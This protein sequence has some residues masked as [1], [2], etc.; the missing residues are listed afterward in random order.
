MDGANLL[1]VFLAGLGS[2]IFGT[3]V[4]GS[5]LITT[6]VLMLL[7]VPPHSAI[8]TDRMG[9]TGI[10]IAGLYTFHRKGLVRYGIGFIV[11]IPCLLGSFVGANIALQID[12]AVLRKV[13]V[14]LTVILL[15]VVSA[16]PKLGVEKDQRPLKTGDYVK[17]IFFSLLVG[18]YSGFYGAG[19]AIFLSY[20]MVLVFRQTF[21]ESAATMKVG[22][23][24]M[25]ATPALTFAYHGAIHYPFALVMFLGSCVGSFTG[26]HYSE[27]IG[28]VWIQ[29]LFIGIVL[30][31]AVKLLF[32]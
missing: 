16:S 22:A 28:N 25:T 3:L 5:S 17:G 7:G 8:G 18:A 30:L 31:M 19:A 32:P 6:P 2:S 20:I 29:R 23:I 9:V 21:L 1:I 26:A 24:M 12:P 11:G 27:R 4:G 14:A 13:I 15:V 10:G